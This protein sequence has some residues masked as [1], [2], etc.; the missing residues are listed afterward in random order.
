M[1]HAIGIS[2]LGD[3]T[4]LDRI[5]I[6]VVQAVR[7]DSLS[8]VVAQGKGASIHAA[9]VSA[10]LESTETFFG[11]RIS[12]F[13]TIYTTARSLQIG[14]DRFQKHLLPSAPVEWQTISTA[15][16]TAHDL[17]TGETCHVPLELVH[18]AFVD[19]PL[20]S[21]G[22][23][24]GSTNGLAVAFTES[25]ATVHGL[26]ECIERDALATAAVTHGFFQRSR[27]DLQTIED[28]ALNDLLQR[29]RDA[30]VLIGLWW[31][32]GVGATPVIWCHLME[33]KVED[34]VLLPQ[35]ADGSAAALDPRVAV[36]RAIEEAAQSRLAAISGVRDDVTRAHYPKYPKWDYIN[37]H[38]RLITQGPR[39]VDFRQ[40]LE[41]S[42]NGGSN[43]LP[44][45]LNTLSNVPDASVLQIR[46]DTTPITDLTAVKVVTPMLQPPPS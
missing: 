4:G 40:I 29:L 41:F 34:A 27:I 22:I 3:I 2:R 17:L 7:P 13:E 5:G 24:A 9:A 12:M 43:W 35:P 25:D 23:F 26:L 16:T 28:T 19:P 30:G 14:A 15:W 39:E 44:A 33:E 1:L 21:D 20:Q 32:S 45:L 42:P 37:A 10:I 36:R 11:E 6:P 18:T 8:H 38:R 31:M 46:L